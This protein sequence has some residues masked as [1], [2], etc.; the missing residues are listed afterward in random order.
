[1]PASHVRAG[2]GVQVFREGLVPGQGPSLPV[3]K[4]EN[5]V[6]CNYEDIQSKMGVVQSSGLIVSSGLA[7]HLTGPENRL[8]GRRQM[9]I[10]NLG[11]A[12]VYLGGSGVTTANGLQIA[13]NEKFSLDVLDVGD[14]FVASAGTSDV[15]ILEMK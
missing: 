7:I 14:I 1:M 15:R 9:I 3:L 13:I 10:Q 11:N 8:R 2:S 5:S 4:G 6:V 12:P